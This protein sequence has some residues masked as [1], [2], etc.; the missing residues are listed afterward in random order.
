M[1]FPWL[2]SSLWLVNQ[3]MWPSQDHLQFWR[4]CRLKKIEGSWTFKPFSHF[5]FPPGLH[6]LQVLFFIDLNRTKIPRIKSDVVLLYYFLLLCS[7]SFLCPRHFYGWLLLLLLYACIFSCFFLFILIL[8][9]TS[10]CSFQPHL[11][12]LHSALQ[13]LRWCFRGGWILITSPTI[14]TFFAAFIICQNALNGHWLR[15][16]EV[17]IFLFSGIFF[18]CFLSSLLRS[19]VQSSIWC[20]KEKNDNKR[21]AF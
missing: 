8:L 1:Q 18:L 11:A 21:N 12:I 17:S 2:W 13:F 5:S 6:C 10:L 7:C 15:Y 14:R 4:D 9:F 19:F 3:I 20:V 16:E